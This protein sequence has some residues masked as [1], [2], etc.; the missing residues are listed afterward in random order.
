MH[1][2]ITYR[3]SIDIYSLSHSHRYSTT[4]LSILTIILLH[5][6]HSL[7]LKYRAQTHNHN[8][9]QIDCIHDITSSSIYLRHRRQLLASAMASRCS[10]T[11]RSSCSTPAPLT[12]EVLMRS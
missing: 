6:S 4:A 10:Q 7:A 8:H 3:A 1:H 2:R 11:R 9:K 12:D 5:Y